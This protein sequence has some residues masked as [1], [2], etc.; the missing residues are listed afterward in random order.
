LLAQHFVDPFNRV[1]ITM[2]S[3]EVFAPKSTKAALNC[4]SIR[5]SGMGIFSSHCWPYRGLPIR[6]PSGEYEMGTALK[7]V[8]SVAVAAIGTFRDSH[9]GTSCFHG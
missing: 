4:A 9:V 1:V 8:I 6:A 3:G 2:C 7:L 5:I